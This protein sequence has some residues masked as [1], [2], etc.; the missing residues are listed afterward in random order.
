M[1]RFQYHFIPLLC[2][3]K[4][5][6]VI[7]RANEAYFDGKDFPVL[8]SWINPLTAIWNAGPKIDA[9]DKSSRF[10]LLLLGW[11]TVQLV[12][13]AYEIWRLWRSV[14][15][16]LEYVPQ[17]PKSILASSPTRE[18]GAS[19]SQAKPRTR[20]Q[21]SIPS[22]TADDAQAGPSRG[23]GRPKPVTRSS[24]SVNSAMASLN[25]KDGGDAESQKSRGS[26]TSRKGKGKARADD[27]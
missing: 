18:S 9:L 6:V 8:S 24:R 7:D 5:G 14:S 17:P 4:F 13:K 26:G 19:K 15:L 1:E 23:V 3:Q 12:T 10:S 22:K 27:E 20:S 2:T 21:M 11:P 16:P 25:L